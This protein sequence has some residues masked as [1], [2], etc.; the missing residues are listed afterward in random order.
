MN[1]KS[2][3]KVDKQEEEEDEGDEEDEE[4]EDDVVAIAE[5]MTVSQ[6]KQEL[7]NVCLFSFYS[8]SLVFFYFLFFS[9]LSFSFL[10]VNVVMQRGL[11]T[12]GKKA[13]LVKRMAAR[14]E[15]EKDPT[16]KPRGPEKIRHC[17]WC[18]EV[19]VKKVKP[20]ADRYSFLFPFPSFPLPSLSSTLPP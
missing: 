9:Y 11:I 7:S 10:V 14:L 20:R 15:R 13:D 18:G 6:L 3:K 8:S 12:K 2:T 1:K 19:M 17:N 4:E 5:S 16:Y